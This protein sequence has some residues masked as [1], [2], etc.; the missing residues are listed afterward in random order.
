MKI[1]NEILLGYDR[2]HSAEDVELVAAKEEL[3]VAKKELEKEKVRFAELME[4]SIE[5]GSK[6]LLKVRVDLYR[7][8]RN[9]KAPGWDVERV[10]R[11]YEEVT[12]ED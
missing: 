8:Y 2:T 10:I 5:V 1:A 7:E 12:S 9:D 3:G 6:A 11:E 4:E